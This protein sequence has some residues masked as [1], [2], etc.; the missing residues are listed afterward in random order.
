MGQRTPSCGPRT[1]GGGPSGQQG[2]LRQSNRCSLGPPRGPRRGLRCPWL[3]PR[4]RRPF[5]ASGCTP[6]WRAAGREARILSALCTA[7]LLRGQPPAPGTPT[8][9]PL[10]PPSPAAPAASAGCDSTWAC[11]SR[12][13]WSHRASTWRKKETAGWPRAWGFPMLQYAM[14]G[15]GREEGFL[16][17]WASSR[18]A[19][20]T[21]SPRTAYSH[22]RTE[23]LMVPRCTGAR[24][25]GGRG[26][27]GC[28]RCCY[29]FQ[30]KRWRGKVPGRMRGGGGGRGGVGRCM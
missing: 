27:R 5:L 3:R 22:S 10:L 21:M 24:G 15:K 13:G 28:W 2:R 14:E 17:S 18:P 30:E 19:R 6:P 11:A 4:G 1:R 25:T 20:V 8:P 9:P 12:G 16:A 7:V 23:A 29:R 26:G